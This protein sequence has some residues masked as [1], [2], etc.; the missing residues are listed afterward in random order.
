MCSLSPVSSL[1]LQELTLLLVERGK[2]ASLELQHFRDLCPVGP[3][4]PHLRG[5]ADTAVLS[6]VEAGRS[7]SQTTCLSLANTPKRETKNKTDSTEKVERLK[8]DNQRGLSVVIYNRDCKTV[9]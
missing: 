7:R 2:A 6:P 5:A 4:K 1:P 8:E 9:N 3:V